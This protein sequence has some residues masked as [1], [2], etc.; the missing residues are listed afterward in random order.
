MAVLV[1]FDRSIHLSTPFGT[2]SDIKCP[3]CDY[4]CG[5]SGKPQQ[6]GDQFRCLDC[7]ATWREL[8]ASSIVVKL[9][10]QNQS[11]STKNE[12][13]KPLFEMNDGELGGSGANY[14]DKSKTVRGYFYA[15]MA[16]AVFTA[17][18]TVSNFFV[19][20]LTQSD[21]DYTLTGSIQR[22]TLYI[23]D[24]QLNERVRPKGEKVFTVQGVIMNETGREKLVPR[25]VIILRKQNGDEVFRWH[26]KS[27]LA[28]LTD[29]RK[30]RFS[31]SVQY[32]TPLA[33]IADAKF[34]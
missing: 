26:Y 32:D 20:S 3:A 7:G 29:G 16:A 28:L 13:H 24:I 22:D 11:Q 1:C 34:E 33:L 19:Q 14:S 4:D 21:I 25:I 30:L 15:G 27:P 2:Q 6:D 31:T 5:T 9:E 8:D 23:D 18:L 10:K 12:F 17:C